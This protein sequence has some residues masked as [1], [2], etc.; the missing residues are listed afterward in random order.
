MSFNDPFESSNVNLSTSTAT[1]ST[2]LLSSVR[3]E[4]QAREEKRRYDHAARKIQRVWRGRSQAAKIRLWVLEEM[5]SGGLGDWRRQASGLVIL[6]NGGGSEE[7][8]LNRRKR[9]VLVR[10]C[11]AGLSE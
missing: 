1:S 2:A 7:A 6:S 10:C 8:T 11:R 5:E 9:E 4:R 3:A